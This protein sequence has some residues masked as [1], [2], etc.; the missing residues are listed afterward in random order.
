MN[1][2]E[3]S[4]PAIVAVKSPNEAVIPAE[5]PMEPRA[6]TKGNAGRQSTHRAQNRASVT[7]ALDRVRQAAPKARFAVK[8]PR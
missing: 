1:D 3:K 6:G 2:Q 8:H 4:D 7:Q 5:E